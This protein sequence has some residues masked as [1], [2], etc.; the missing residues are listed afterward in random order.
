[1]NPA[2]VK[3]PA[4]YPAV[5]FPGSPAF[6]YI[7]IPFCDDAPTR[8]LFNAPA[9]VKGL[10]ELNHLSPKTREMIAQKFIRACI[11]NENP[12]ADKLIRRGYGKYGW[13]FAKD[14][15]ATVGEAMQDQIPT[16]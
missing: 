10:P 7:W 6:E 11:E 13:I 16:E 15:N 14:I 4:I 9:I 12:D 1:M 3:I 8:G 5:I 2:K